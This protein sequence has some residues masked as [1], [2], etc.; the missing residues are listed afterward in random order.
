MI[1]NGISAM[2]F[3]EKPRAREL[4]EYRENATLENKP[5]NAGGREGDHVYFIASHI[6]PRNAKRPTLPDVRLQ[7]C[8]LGV[9]KSA[10]EK[11]EKSSCVPV[12]NRTSLLAMAP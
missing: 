10:V 1:G 7:P 6:Q 11:L 3:A 5:Q 8:L 2:F 12:Q 4:K 9:N